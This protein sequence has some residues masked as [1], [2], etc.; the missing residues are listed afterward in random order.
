MQ[1]TLLTC[2][3]REIKYAPKTGGFEEWETVPCL[4]LA[5]VVEF[6]ALA[7]NPR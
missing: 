5:C 1:L 7:G 4:R 2:D 3:G 6:A